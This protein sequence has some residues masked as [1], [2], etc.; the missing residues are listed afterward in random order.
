MTAPNTELSPP[1]SPLP[2]AG[3]ERRGWAG[4]SRS[5]PAP[6]RGLC[7]GLSEGVA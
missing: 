3:A 1:H 6:A 7:G 5:G 2:G 4:G